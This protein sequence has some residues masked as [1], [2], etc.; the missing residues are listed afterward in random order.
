MTAHPAWT[1]AS[2]PGIVPLHPFSF[3]TILGRS[4][5]ALRQNPRVL[6]GFALLIQTVA[7]IVVIVAVGAVGFAAFSRLET[8]RPGTEEYET[9][10][11]GSIALTGVVGL[12][13]GLAAGALSV[14]VQG[15]VVMEVIHAVVAERLTLGALWRRVK[16][17]FWRLFGYSALIITAMLVVLGVVAGIV[18]GLA[19]VA[20]P[21]AVV[22]GIL[23]VLALVPLYWWLTIKLVLVPSSILVERATIRGAIRRSWMLTRGR[24]WSSLGV[25]FL[26]G[27]IFGAVAQVVSIPFSFISA[28]LS[29]VISP[30]GDLDA[31]GFIA[32]IVSTLL[33]YVVALL[34]QSIAI[35]VQST[36]TALI[37]VDCRMRHEGLDLDLMEYVERRDA[38]AADLPD[39][40]LQHVGRDQPS[41]YLV[42]AAAYHA[43]GYPQPGYPPAYPAPQQGYPSAYPPPYAPAQG[44]PPA[45][46]PPAAPA[47]PTQWAP[48]VSSPGE[49]GR[50]TT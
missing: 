34:V 9:I 49:T 11:A 30:T 32:I 50:E 38:G 7:Y 6:L 26:I 36:A 45:P 46:T 23:S 43:P 5:V 4:F 15:V 2:R 47:P 3:G 24:F 28:G 8:V 14:I 25:I 31:S 16:P 1:P 29:T 20:V 40:Y 10:M 19:L 12:L 35:V 42:P 33:T 48:P 17:V 27:A 22:L 18:A 41:P 39:P 44:Y 37:Y 13:L 21:V